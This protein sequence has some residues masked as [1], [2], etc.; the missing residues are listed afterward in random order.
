MALRPMSRDEAIQH[1]FVLAIAVFLIVSPIFLV[2]PPNLEYSLIGLG[3][4]F[5]LIDLIV[6]AALRRPLS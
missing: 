3:A 5:G 6:A 1:L 4:L 2:Q